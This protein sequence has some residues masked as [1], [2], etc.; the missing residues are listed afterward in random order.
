MAIYKNTPPAIVSGSVLWL[1]AANTKSYPRSGIIWNDLSGNLNSG[2]LVNSPTFSNEGGGSLIFNGSTQYGTITANPTTA[3]NGT[4]YT[5]SAWVKVSS[6]HASGYS[7][8]FGRFSNTPYNGYMLEAN[9]ITGTNKFCMVL[10]NANSVSRFYA[11][12]A[13]IF[14]KWYY[15]VSTSTSNVSRLYIDG[16]IQTNTSAFTTATDST[17]PIMIGKFFTVSDSNNY[18]LIG[19]LA[20]TSIYNR[21][22]T[23]QEIQQ[24]YNSL[25]SRFNIA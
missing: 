19:S 24:N 20:Q 16:V 17:Y 1:D 21:V 3:F 14:N 22:L 15:V 4:N 9:N 7:G 10:G 13:I 5:I 23:A 18:Y 12:S 8:I 2:S 6:I 11:D 25:K